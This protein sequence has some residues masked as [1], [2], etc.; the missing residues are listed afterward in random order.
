[1][2]VPLHPLV[3]AGLDGS[4]SSGAVLEWA[5]RQA[6][7]WRGRVRVVMAWHL[8][9]VPGYLPS[10]VEAAFDEA[11][12]KLVEELIADAFTRLDL[13][14][15]QVPVETVVQEGGAVRLLLAHAAD[16]DV[17]VLGRHGHGRDHAKLLGSVT[18]SC[19]MQ[20]PCPVV[21]VPVDA[22]A[23]GPAPT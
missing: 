22:R 2:T 12:E 14:R 23:D 15:Q 4:P 1:M 7:V 9:E 16:A 20:A 6:L 18:Q 3:V 17:L 13:S 19:L 5:L 11:T 21:V 8:P 10:R